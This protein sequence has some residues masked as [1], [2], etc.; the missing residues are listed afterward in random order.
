MEVMPGLRI[1]INIIRIE[2]MM[3]YRIDAP[4]YSRN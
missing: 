3:S 4:R 1:I 2:V